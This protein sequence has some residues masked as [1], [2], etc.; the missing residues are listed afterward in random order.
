MQSKNKITI[1]GVDVK[2]TGRFLKTASLNDE[3]YVPSGDP[4]RIIAGLK[5]AGVQADLL[6]FVQELHDRSPKHEYHRETDEMAVLPL[7]TFDNW[8]NKQITFK[9]R[10]KIRK[11]WKNGVETRKVEFT[12]E[13]L[14]GIKDIYDETPIRQGKRNWH[15]QKD[16][17]TLKRE[18]STFLDRS[19]FVGAYFGGELIGFVKVTHAPNYSIIMNIVSKVAAR[20]RAPTNALI[21]KTIEL[22]TARNIPLLNYGV[23]GR[24]GLNDF[25]TASAFECCQVPRYY[26]PLTWKGRLALKWKLH[27]G[28]KERLPE[29]WIIKLA[30]WRTKWNE[31]RFSQAAPEAPAEHSAPAESKA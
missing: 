20:D 16:F 13:L 7:T 22:V 8:F 10:N 29:A 1:E 21:A 18:H 15:Y 2:V 26:V 17:E 4:A 31:R 30:G 27:R 25:K 5:Q 19:E 9:P 11:A 23:W 6:T 24:R 14:R 12:D 3:Y 28:V